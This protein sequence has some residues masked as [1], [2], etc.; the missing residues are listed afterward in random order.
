MIGADG[1]QSGPHPGKDL[2]FLGATPETYVW[3]EGMG[4]EWK[5]A[6]EVEELKVLFYPAASATTPVSSTPQPSTSYNPGFGG[7]QPTQPMG[8]NTNPYQGTNQGYGQGMTPNNQPINI[9]VT[10]GPQRQPIAPGCP[11]S[12][13]WLSICTTLL[14]CLVTGIVACVYSS[15]VTTQW[16]MG[17]YEGAAKSSRTALIWN[18]VGVGLD[19][20]IGIL[21]VVV[22]VLILGAAAY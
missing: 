4:A 17:D 13:M 18:L 12:W 5:P 15:K 10:T 1:Q 16:A 3:C 14:C 6:G 21:Y 20:V 2:K 7:G 19:A 22:W 11:N 8:G 9:N